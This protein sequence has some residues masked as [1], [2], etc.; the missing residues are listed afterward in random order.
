MQ[1]SKNALFQAFVNSIYENDFFFFNIFSNLFPLLFS[2][3]LEATDDH[4]KDTSGPKNR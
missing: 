3:V 4:M 1:K 2:F